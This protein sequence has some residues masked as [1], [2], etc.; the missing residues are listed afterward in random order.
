MKSDKTFIVIMCFIVAIIIGLAYYYF[1]D[2]T[3]SSLLQ[4]GSGNTINNNTTNGGNSTGNGSSNEGT[5][6]STNTTNG[7]SSPSNDR[8]SL[9]E[10]KDYDDFFTINNLINEFYKIMLES[11]KE[12]VLNLLDASYIKTHKIGSHNVNNYM[13]SGYESIA[14]FSK[15]MYV[16]GRDGILYYFINGETQSYNFADEILTEE[17]D[18]NYMVIVDQNNKSYSITPLVSSI[19]I[20]N[21]SSDYKMSNKEITKN[22]YNKYKSYTLND[23]GIAIYYLNYFKNML[24]LNTEKAYEMLDESTRS[25]YDSYETFVNNLPTLYDSLSTN[26]LSYSS[27]GDSGTRKYSIISNNQVRVDFQEKSSMNFIVSIKN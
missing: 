6:N 4:Q 13:A 10:V 24:F 23:E 8:I 5:S 3:S 15:N 11:D 7:T 1:S 19:S 12:A 16:K 17:R 2:S 14:Y 26:L 18:I 21:Y 20:F 9:T 22:S 25:T 27:K